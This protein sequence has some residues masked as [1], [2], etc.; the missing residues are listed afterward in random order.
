MD[1]ILTIFEFCSPLDLLSISSTSKELI[2]RLTYLHVLRSSLMR[3]GVFHRTSLAV[4]INLC[5]TGK[6][7]IPS[8][9]RLL[10]LVNGHH[11]EKA[12]CTLK[13]SHS[14][15]N[16]GLTNFGLCFCHSCTMNSLNRL[17]LK[18]RGAIAWKE[19]VLDERCASS[20][21]QSKYHIWARDYTHAAER[22]GP[23][24]TVRTINR[25]Y[26]QFEPKTTLLD[27]LKSYLET[28]PIGPKIIFDTYD[29]V[30]PESRAY[31]NSVAKRKF[32]ISEK[33]KV[34]KKKKVDAMEKE[35]FSLLSDATW[36]KLAVGSNYLDTLLAPLRKGTAMKIELLYLLHKL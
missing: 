19:I 32:D 34:N 22:N 20:Y 17:D 35:I 13:I 3:G 15:P 23:V 30:L 5:R 29:T 26:K 6:I 10:R 33:N 36:A 31:H 27:S 1:T 8:P 2:S 11:C 14:T 4:I 9:I 24:I 18:T 7:F 12:G 16:L 21:Y 28:I 25:L